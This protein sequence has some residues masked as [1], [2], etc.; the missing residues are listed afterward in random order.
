M[1]YVTLFIVKIQPAEKKNLVVIKIITLFENTTYT[2][3]NVFFINE[4]PPP[5][6]TT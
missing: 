4:P 2:C 5:K 6:K 1:Y 3:T